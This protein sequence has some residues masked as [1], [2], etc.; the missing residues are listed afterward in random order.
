MMASSKRGILTSYLLREMIKGH[1]STGIVRRKWRAE[2]RENDEL[3]ATTRESGN[4]DA[5][6]GN[7]DRRYRL[8]STRANVQGGCSWRGSPGK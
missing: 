8:T 1:I 3:Q 2:G 4:A 5:T 7:R 6:P